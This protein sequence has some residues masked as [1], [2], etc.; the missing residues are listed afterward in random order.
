MIAGATR[1]R[2]GGALA[3]HFLQQG[4]GAQ[5]VR[6]VDVRELAASAT[7]AAGRPEVA[8]REG[9]RE[10]GELSAHGLT[11][12]WCQ[13]VHVDPP[14]DDPAPRETAARFLSL[15]EAEFQLAGPRIV[16]EHEKGGRVHWHVAYSLIGEDGRMV[17]GLGH[18]H[19]RVEKLARI[20]E[21]ERGLPLTKGAHNRSV[22]AALRREGR[23]GRGVGARAGGVASRGSRPGRGDAPGACAARAVRGPVAAGG[24]GCVSGGLAGVGRGDGRRGGAGGCAPEAGAGAPGGQPGC[25]GG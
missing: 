13:H 22:I 24:R 16:V 9:F 1:G 21:C 18:H 17:D 14:P 8:V 20:T 2:G 7:L 15:Y 5:R 6:V 25:G 3:R 23:E 10:L 19:R 11:D 4:D 12:R